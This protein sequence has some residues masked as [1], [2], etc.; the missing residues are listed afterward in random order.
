MCVCVL[1]GSNGGWKGERINRKGTKGNERMI[2]AVMGCC[3]CEYINCEM[4]QVILIYCYSI[5]A[6][7][8]ILI[9]ILIY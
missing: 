2:T 1:G 6:D 5:D 8:D 3:F 7:T 4:S 9:L